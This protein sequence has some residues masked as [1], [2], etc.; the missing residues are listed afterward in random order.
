MTTKNFY[1]MKELITAAKKGDK[2]A[3]YQLGNKFYM[4][5]GIEQDF[6]EAKYWFQQASSHGHSG[7]TLYLEIMHRNDPA[8]E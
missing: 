3:Q 4:G 7:A 2:D 6:D 1:K 8:L 5:I